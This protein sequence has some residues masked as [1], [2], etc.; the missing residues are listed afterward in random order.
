V[1]A[2]WE[3][4]GDLAIPKAVFRAVLARIAVLCNEETPNAVS[5]YGGQGHFSGGTGS[6]VFRVKFS[7]TSSQQSLEL[8]CPQPHPS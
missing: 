6:D 2:N 4:L 3:E 7:N 5:P 8:G 1:G